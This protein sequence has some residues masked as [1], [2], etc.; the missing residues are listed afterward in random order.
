MKGDLCIKTLHEKTI[1]ITVT[2]E[3]LIEWI[4]HKMPVV[5]DYDFDSV[6][7]D[8]SLP[9]ADEILFVFTHE[10]RSSSVGIIL[11]NNE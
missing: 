6:E 8:G 7:I 10:T 2:K 1:T 11:D 5:K 4:R 9:F 3:E